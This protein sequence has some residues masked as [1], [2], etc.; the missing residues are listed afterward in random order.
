MAPV[1]GEVL[2]ESIDWILGGCRRPDQGQNGKVERNE[3]RCWF[4]R[5][6]TSRACLI[7]VLSYF[8]NV[9]DIYCWYAIKVG[10]SEIL[11]G[12]RTVVL[13]LCSGE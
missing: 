2:N 4:S 5:G 3:G 1:S 10:S 12:H 6:D 11:G 7:T 13:Q 9:S 8:S